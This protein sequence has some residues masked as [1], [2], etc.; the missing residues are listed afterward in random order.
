MKLISTTWTLEEGL[1]LVRLLQSETRQFNMH[2]VIGGGVVNNGFSNKDLDLYFLPL[3]SED[4]VTDQDGM[5]EWLDTLWGEGR[6]I[7]QPGY[8]PST[9]YAYK[10]EYTVGGKRVDAFIMRG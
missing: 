6:D 7:V 3:G 1:A 10:W 4:H 2:L 5:K 9:A 8:P